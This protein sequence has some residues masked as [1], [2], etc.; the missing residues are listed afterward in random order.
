MRRLVL[1]E[2]LRSSPGEL[3]R[4]ALHELFHFAWVRM[5]N[6]ERRSWE[7]LVR[8]QLLAGASGE[9]G[10]SAEQ[11]LLALRPADTG[12]RSRRWREY[13]CESF[14]D[15]AGWCFGCLRR[16]GEFTLE[17]PLRAERRAWL[18]EFVRHRGGAVPI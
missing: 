14:C 1:D 10:W 8:R 4:I 2:E 13:V 6:Q 18:R 15:A 12:Q 5:S 9:L 16:H 3:A 17:G 11:R 7:E